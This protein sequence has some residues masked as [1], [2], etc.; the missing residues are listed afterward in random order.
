MTRLRVK[1]IRLCVDFDTHECDF[2]THSCDFHTR[3]CDLDKKN[4]FEKLNQI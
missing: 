1:L 2:Q 4:Y 3:A